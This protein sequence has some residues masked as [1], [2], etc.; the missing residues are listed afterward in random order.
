MTY[1]C[2]ECGAGLNIDGDFYFCPICRAE[3]KGLS[4]LEVYYG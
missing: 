3:G 4:G 1:L 2:P